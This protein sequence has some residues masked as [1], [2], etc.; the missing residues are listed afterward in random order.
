ML[1]SWGHFSDLHFKGWGGFDTGDLRLTLPDAI[2]KHNLKFDYMFVTGDIF[3]KGIFDD[4]TK[5]F[6][7]D[8]AKTAGCDM[9]NVIICPGNHDGTRHKIRKRELDSFISERVADK[10]AEMDEGTRRV[11]VDMPF[12]EYKA[13]HKDITGKEPESLLGYVRELDGINLYVLNT[14]VFAG[15]TYPGKTWTKEEEEKNN[16]NLYLCDAKLF[17]LHQEAKD[18]GFSDANL[19]LVIGH[20][21]IECFVPEAQHNLKTFFKSQKIDLYLCGHVH[22]ISNIEVP[23]ASDTRQVS[24]GGLFYGDKAEPS[25]IYGT[26][27]TD[28]GEVVLKSF[29]YD[30][31]P[32]W[33]PNIAAADPYNLGT[34]KY[35]PPRILR[36]P[37]SKARL[38]GES[39]YDIARQWWG[40]DAFSPLKSILTATKKDIIDAKDSLREYADELKKLTEYMHYNGYVYVHGEQFFGKTHLILKTIYDVSTRDE[41]CKN[42]D[43]HPIP[44]IHQCF[45]ILGKRALSKD[46][47]VELLIEQAN[48]VMG[49]PIALDKKD[50]DKY[51]FS[52]VMQKLSR[53]LEH[54]T[55]V[56]D[57]LDEMGVGM[58]DLELFTEP[59]PDN[60]TVVLSSRTKFNKI[61]K[62]IA[63]AK[64][65][66]LNGFGEKDILS[67]LGKSK[68]ERN[69]AQFVK[70]LLD[71]TKGNPRFVIEIAKRIKENNNEIPNNFR[72]A[73]YITSLGSYFEGFRGI[74]INDPVLKELLK[75]F[76]IFERVGYLTTEDLQSYLLS[77]GK[78]LDSDSVG[79]ELKPVIDHLDTNEDGKYKLK[80]N[81]YAR[82]L[83]DK[84]NRIDFGMAFGN[85]V[86]WLISEEKI[87]YLFP[88]FSSWNFQKETKED[89]TNIIIE[90]SNKILDYLFARKVYIKVYN[91]TLMEF[92]CGIS[93]RDRE[94]RPRLNSYIEKCF[95]MTEEKDDYDL[96]TTYFRY[97]YETADTDAERD[98]AI[99]FVKTMAD[100]GNRSASLCLADFLRYGDIYTQR[101]TEAALHYADMAGDSAESLKLKYD[102][103]IETGN[104]APLKELVGK[105]AGYDDAYA[106]DLY[107]WH[108]A[109][110]DFCAKDIQASCEIFNRLIANGNTQSMVTKARLI[111]NGVF[112]NYTIEEAFKLWDAASH[113]KTNG[114]FFKGNYLYSNGDKE[115]GLALIE[116]AHSLGSNQA[117]VFIANENIDNC[118][119]FNPALVD[120]L[121]AIV[122]VACEEN[123]EAANLIYLGVKNRLIGNYRRY[124]LN[125]LQRLGSMTNDVT[126]HNRVALQLYEDKHYEQA[127][128]RFE[129][130]FL[131]GSKDAATNMAYMLRKGYVKSSE[132]SVE[133]LLKPL[134]EENNAVTTVNYVLQMI[135]ASDDCRVYDEAIGLMGKIDA[136]CQTCNEAI[137]WWRKLA[138]EN[139]A[140]GD[141]VLGLLMHTGK[142][143]ADPDGKEMQARLKRASAAGYGIADYLLGVKNAT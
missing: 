124:D 37:A 24:C 55:V 143:V 12:E 90:Q 115:A 82:H 38:S 133:A 81:A 32:Q 113:F 123:C 5:T 2:T 30:E 91:Q 142:L 17:N 57:A 11:L 84:Y 3:N 4:D 14:A 96:V 52:S 106:Q 102:I 129:R 45:V 86:D 109:H 23:A 139:D 135:E 103:Y 99:S 94:M 112:D 127:F 92:M 101:D 105:L 60:C 141:L 97:L 56:F 130:A 42:F 40:K 87:K 41:Y 44:W 119:K 28:T 16:S 61:K 65:L 34:H 72:E 110:G 121:N 76:A 58:V 85:V 31:K 117:T 138:D 39:I 6:I 20:H 79:Q 33:A 50:Y 66:E 35:T 120:R 125:K 70:F 118:I 62:K 8:L 78:R 29:K 88:L 80:Y 7:R 26:F 22:K 15:Q 63:N 64:S 136:D 116:K 114:Y 128:L 51:G 100:N 18:K 46:K 95:D 43:G 67:I 75:L 71:N 108:L 53:R 69:V 21:G 47:A 137:D 131:C 98:Y 54:V 27:D 36:S 25:F 1:V 89:K 83:A 77:I 49:E 126:K 68:K 104:T 93:R 107:A 134:L 9:G 10:S 74:W 19:N 48:A 122:S 13:A 111:A 140:E 132:Y 59:L 73:K